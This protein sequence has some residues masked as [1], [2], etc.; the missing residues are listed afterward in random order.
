MQSIKVLFSS[1]INLAVCVQVAKL[2][3]TGW[4]EM[5]ELAPAMS[6]PVHM[7]RLNNTA[8]SC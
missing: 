5:V 7:F 4:A 6:S 3:V 2:S 8:E 1:L